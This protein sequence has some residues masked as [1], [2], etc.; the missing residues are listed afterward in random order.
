VNKQVKSVECAWEHN[1]HT[2]IKGKVY[3]K[4]EVTINCAAIN[5]P[6]LVILSGTVCKSTL[7]SLRIPVLQELRVGYSFQT[8][9]KSGVLNLVLPD[10]QQTMQC[11]E[12]VLEGLFKYYDHHRV[13]LSAEDSYQVTAYI[14]CRYSSPLVDFPNLQLGYLPKMK[15]H[16]LINPLNAELNPISHLLALLAHHIF[17]ITGLRVKSNQEDPAI[18]PL[19]YYNR[20]SVQPFGCRFSERHN[21]S[22][23]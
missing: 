9:V 6:Q 18:I 21:F 5:S 16:H 7:E 4:K 8:S 3:P 1:Q 12:G 17:H 13:P 22:G 11:D 19:S 20:I 2:R 23:T 15:I 14:Y 10:P